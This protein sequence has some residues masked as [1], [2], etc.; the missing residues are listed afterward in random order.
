MAKKALSASTVLSQVKETIE[1][2]EEFKLAFGEPESCGTW[3]VWGGS[4]N[5][6][7]SFLMMMAKELARTQKVLYNSRE[8][9]TSL[10]FMMLLE[11]Y[12]MVDCGSNFM[13]IDEDIDELEKRLSKRRSPR[14][15]FID[16]VQYTSWDYPSY[17]KFVQ[18]FPKHLFIINSQCKGITPQG[19]T[20]LKIQYDAMLKIWVEG[21]RA[22]TKGRFIGERGW[23]NIWDEGAKNYWGDKNKKT[24]I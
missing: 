10:S 15:V 9:G 23:I 3:F 13:V 16:S 6:K 14:I 1:F 17:R 12:S 20:A 5:G 18:K 19:K 11:R 8:E 21:Y 7:S 4:G 2:S 22:H 24:K